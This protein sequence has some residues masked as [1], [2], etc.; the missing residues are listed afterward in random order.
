MKKKV[1]NRVLLIIVFIIFG[2][3]LLANENCPDCPGIAPIDGT[4]DVPIDQVVV[5]FLF[6][7]VITAYYLLQKHKP[8]KQ[9]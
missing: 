3:Q 8:Q 9:G 6:V 4:D 7:G 2:Q 5:C 1:I